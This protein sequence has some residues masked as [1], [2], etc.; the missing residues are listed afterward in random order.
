MYTATHCIALRTTAVADNRSLLNAWSRESGFITLALPAGASREG[1]RRRALSVPLAMFEGAVDVRPGRE[2]LS[3]R[4]F[5]PMPGSVALAPSS[6][7]RAMVCAFLA[8]VLTVILR[9]TGPDMQLS[10]YLFEAVAL[11]GRGPE[12]PSS[13]YHLGFLGALTRHIGIA[14]DLSAWTAGSVLD[15]RD[16]LMRPSAPLHTDFLAGDDAL[17]FAQLVRLGPGGAGKVHLDRSGRQKALG[18][19]LHYLSV[20]LGALPPLRSLDVL[21]EMC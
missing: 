4:D 15:M 8:E 7:A 6:P 19:I 16:G 21:R 12:L 5:M 10:D 13:N 18:D 1:R 11:A 20:H 2:V 14:P 17:T 9:R 3:M